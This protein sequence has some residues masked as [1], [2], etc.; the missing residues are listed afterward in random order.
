[1]QLVRKYKCDIHKLLDIFSTRLVAEI[2]PIYLKKIQV[3]SN[4]LKGPFIWYT[5]FRSTN[6]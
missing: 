6:L 2:Y 5:N 4:I 3:K 1:M